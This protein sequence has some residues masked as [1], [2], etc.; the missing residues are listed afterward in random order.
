MSHRRSPAAQQTRLLR[1]MIDPVVWAVFLALHIKRREHGI[2]VIVSDTSMPETE[3]LTR[4]R[5][6]L[7]L[8]RATD[9]LRFRWIE[10]YVRH[11]VVWPGD[12]TAYDRRGGIHVSGRYLRAAPEAVL[13]GG[14]VHEAVHLRIQ[15]CRVQYEPRL[16]ERIETRCTREQAAFLRNVPGR[17]P[18]WAADAEADLAAP[19]WTE[20]HRRARV[21]RAG[22]QAGLAAWATKLLRRFSSDE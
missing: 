13:A 18:S 11:I 2:T 1:R 4:I 16:R 21:E 3:A 10:R 19:W 20:E 9:P 15:R 7:G 12:Y 22:K 6:V 5:G 17:G 14:L 8:L